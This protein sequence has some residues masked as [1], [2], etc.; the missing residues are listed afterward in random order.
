MSTI[1]AFILSLSPSE[2]PYSAAAPHAAEITES[3]GS[4]RFYL[5]KAIFHEMDS[6]YRAEVY[7]FL[8][9]PRMELEGGQMYEYE[10]S[11]DLKASDKR[12]PVNDKWTG[13]A[14]GEWV[15]DKFDLYLKPGN[16]S[17]DVDIR[18]VEVDSSGHASLTL[19][20][21]EPS[22]A[23]AVSDV[24]LAWKFGSDTLSRFCRYGIEAVPNPL[25]AYNPDRDTL[26]YLLEIYNLVG[27][28]G[29]FGITYA[30][31]D[32]NGKL[33][34]A[35][36]PTFKEKPGTKAVEIGGILLSDLSDGEYTLDFEVVDMAVGKRAL[37]S[38]EFLYYTS[39][40]EPEVIFDTTAIGF[41]D[42]FAQPDELK[43]FKGLDDEGKQFYLLKFWAARDPIP[44]TPE[45]EF[46]ME[47]LMRVQ[48]AD[49]NFIQGGAQ[50]RYTDRGRIYIKYGP[51]DERRKVPF[52]VDYPDREEWYYYGE[53]GR[54]FIFVDIHGGDRYELVFSNT[55]EE[56]GYHDWQMYVPPDEIRGDE[57]GW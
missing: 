49:S 19:K 39:Y 2:D 4:L 40:G 35:S 47:F 37:A 20:V 57:E 45:N 53:G 50:G 1:L 15:V 21:P 7:Y 36:K 6:L 30:V 22:L 52:S 13:K 33:I 51:P 43:E 46:L 9:V 24:K 18:S 27:D 28:S 44:E 10:V 12:A 54:E 55:E 8:S 31:Y 34:K 56:R 3:K 25:S 16:Y 5:D 23:L 41:I 14:L 32:E 11:V 26:Y 17:L 42:Y 48:Y 29:R 38:K